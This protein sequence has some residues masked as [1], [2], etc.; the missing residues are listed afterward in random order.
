MHT[1]D[2]G[3]TNPDC[4]PRIQAQVPDMYHSP[5]TVIDVRD[6]WKAALSERQY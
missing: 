1:N 5:D 6:R 4:K 3:Y 2:E